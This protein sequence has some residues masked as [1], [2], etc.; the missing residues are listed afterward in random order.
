MRRGLDLTLDLAIH[1]EGCNHRDGLSLR[2]LETPDD[3]RYFE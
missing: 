2:S 3:A 1:G